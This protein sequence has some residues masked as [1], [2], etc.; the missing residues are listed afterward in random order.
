MRV[1]LR[2]LTGRTLLLA[3]LGL[4]GCQGAYYGA[5]EKVGVHKRDIMVSRVEAA[6]DSQEETKEQFISAL[7]QF[8]QVV[9]FDGGALE[10]EYERLDRKF[11]RSEAGAREVSDRIDAVQDVSQALFDE[12]QEELALYK[13]ERLRASSARQLSATRERYRQMLGAMRKAERS[14]Q[15]VLNAFRDRV[16]FLKHNLNARAVASLKG[17]LSQVERDV[18]G[19]VQEMQ[20]SIDESNAFIEQLGTA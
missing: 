14:M 3:V 1:C 6:R 19:L 2:A 12:W 8:S 18:A 13:D 15:P 17:E 20:R 11:E 9:N 16:L 10:T 5:L 4:S 7:E